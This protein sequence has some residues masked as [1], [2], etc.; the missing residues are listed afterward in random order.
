MIRAASAVGLLF[1]G[2]IAEQAMW[3]VANV[4]QF[5]NSKAPIVA[6]AFPIR[7]VRHRGSGSQVSIGSDGQRDVLPISKRDYEMTKGLDVTRPP[8]QFCLRLLRQEEGQAV[9]IWRPSRPRLS[10][11]GT[12]IIRCPEQVRGIP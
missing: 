12:T 8:W 7:S 1:G 10:F 11:T 6:T 9:R 5:W 2:L 4:Y 3:R